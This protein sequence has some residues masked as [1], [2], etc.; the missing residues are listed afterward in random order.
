MLTCESFKVLWAGPWN[1]EHVFHLNFRYGLILLGFQVQ[2]AIDKRAVNVRFLLYVA[3]GRALCAAAE[4]VLE[5]ASA[6]LDT[7]IETRSRKLY[8]GR[9]FRSMA[10]LD[11]PTWDD[12]AV[13]SHINS[14]SPRMPDSDTVAWT[15]IKSLVEMG[16]AFLRMFSEAAVLFRVLRGQGDGSLLVLASV[17]SKAVS[18]LDYTFRGGLNLGNSMRDIS[19]SVSRDEPDFQVGLPSRAIVI[20]SEWRASIV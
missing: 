18:F 11:V 19:S 12:P 13:S 7:A 15:A 5:Y 10:R 17:A 8:W 20:M 1:S 9:I 16:S 2:S 6:K 14:L 4:R 3:G